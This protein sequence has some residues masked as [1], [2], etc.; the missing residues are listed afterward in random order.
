MKND[1]H[2]T[3]NPFDLGEQLLR[4]KE[5]SGVPIRH[6]SGVLEDLEKK[7]TSGVHGIHPSYSLLA[8]TVR[9]I[10]PCHMWVCGGYTSSGKTFFLTDLLCRLYRA[11]NPGVALFSTE[12]SAGQ[13]ALRMLANRTTYSTWAIEERKFINPTHLKVLK[14]AWDHFQ[15]R[16]LYLYDDL[17]DW[18]RIEKTV[19]AIKYRKGLDIVA[20]D[21]IQNLAG[22]G[23]L[24]ERMSALSPRIQAM[25]KRLDV[26]AIVLSQVS[27][28][29]ARDDLTI[30]GY[31]GAGEIAA[32]ADLGIWLQRDEECKE[33]VRFMVRKNRHGMTGEGALVYTDNY[34]RFEEKEESR[35]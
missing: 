10:A 34:T 13:Y 7:I 6:I 28:E 3:T 12:M 31:K 32:A 4:D 5:A 20:I 11:G 18:K 26:C 1:T 30:L 23:S 14:D 22:K 15:T 8:K 9:K 16:N 24:Y 2:S 19:E 29:A 27:N 25:A 21:F 17:Y 33:I 35:G